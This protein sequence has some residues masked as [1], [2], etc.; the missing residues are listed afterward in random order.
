MLRSTAWSP[1]NRQGRHHMPADTSPSL[2]KNSSGAGRARHRKILNIS[3]KPE[4]YWSPRDKKQ[5]RNFLKI[6]FPS[7]IMLKRAVLHDEKEK[8][9]DN[10]DEDEDDYEAE[11]FKLVARRI[12]ASCVP[13]PVQVIIH[14]VSRHGARHTRYHFTSWQQLIAPDKTFPRLTLLMR[15]SVFS[16]IRV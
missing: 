12:T 2:V 5:P 6:T 9:C 14:R 3:L 8:Q 1:K 16:R 7:L 11:V 15:F 10:F 4:W 13:S